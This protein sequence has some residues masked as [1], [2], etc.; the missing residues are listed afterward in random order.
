MALAALGAACSPVTS[1]LPGESQSRQRQ[2]PLLEERRAWSLDMVDGIENSCDVYFYD[3]A[4]RVG[5]DRIADI[6]HL[7]GFG[8]QVGS[9]CRARRTA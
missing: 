9:T 7:F 3:L 8:S 4:R 6:A 2:V 1:L 5:I